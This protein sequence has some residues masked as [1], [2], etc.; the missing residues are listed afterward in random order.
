MTY[1]G[2]AYITALQVSTVVFLH[3]LRAV[4]VLVSGLDTV[5]YVGNKRFHTCAGKHNGRHR[6]Q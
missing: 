2:D 4:V 5:S 3:A 6:E 1:S